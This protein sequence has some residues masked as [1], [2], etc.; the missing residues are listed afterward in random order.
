M[1]VS[2]RTLS[3]LPE[4]SS[5]QL[6]P[7]AYFEVSNPVSAI[8]DLN[9][10]IISVNYI[11]AS[12]KIK[13]E[14]V[15]RGI[16]EDVKYELKNN[17]GIIDQDF[18]WLYRDHLS[19]VHDSYTLT[20]RK[21]FS[22]NPTHTNEITSFT[23]SRLNN[24]SI[25][26]DALKKYSNL[27]S[28]P[29][30][31]P[32][33]GFVTHLSGT[34]KDAYYNL[35]RIDKNGKQVT[36]TSEPSFVFS[37]SSAK[38]LAQNEF[39]FKIEPG[40]RESKVWEA[41]ASGIFTCYGWLDEIHNE[42]VSN[43]NR[44]IALMGK[45]E[46]LGVWTT[47]QVQP[48]IKNNYLSYV[49]FTFPVHKG[50]KLKVVTGFPVG[51]NSDKYFKNGS[52]L[53]NN[54]ANAFLG[55]VYTGL[56][57][58]NGGNYNLS[59]INKDPVQ[60]FDPTDLCNLVCAQISHELTCDD[61]INSNI[62]DISGR[63][64]I[65]QTEVEKRVK[66]IDTTLPTSDYRNATIVLYNRKLSPNSTTGKDN[67]YQQLYWSDSDTSGS[68]WRPIYVI[69]TEDLCKRND[70]VG[71]GIVRNYYVPPGPEHEDKYGSTENGIV[72]RAYV[73][74][75]VPYGAVF[76]DGIRMFYK[77]SQ[78]CTVLIRCFSDI[79]P[80]NDTATRCAM[81]YGYE[82]NWRYTRCVPMCR[83]VEI[84]GNLTD[85]PAEITL[86][87][88]KG[89]IFM[90][91][92]WLRGPYSNDLEYNVKHD[93]DG[94]TR[95]DFGAS[96]Y[97]LMN[98]PP[99]IPNSD[100]STVRLGTI[101]DSSISAESALSVNSIGFTYPSYLIRPDKEYFDRWVNVD[102]SKTTISYPLFRGGDSGSGA[103]ARIVEMPY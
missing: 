95:D 35:F 69:K 37:P 53:A 21:N 28:S 74:A 23:N 9:G 68:I 57:V 100:G 86:P 22:S 33:F 96:Y 48:F 52:S 8:A 42:K 83:Q 43:E 75:T 79:S 51:S 54:L 70:T 31:S 2:L 103:I 87:V 99:N 38:T 81:L 64:E 17:N 63:V 32:Q 94:N 7:N 58:D 15:S 36:V 72:E 11:Y 85:P 14:E 30:I 56:S 98:M 90:F 41:P 78:D 39:V 71:V 5:A 44:W 73:P 65:L 19:L 62:S 45:Q 26:L 77:V 50:L 92:S 13:K 40:E 102:S 59:F 76:T 6:A 10:N 66:Y 49:G 1:A 46:Q 3:Q 82:T 34:S 89:T 25:N 97:K 80:Y 60:N 4:I 93:K 61:V 20:G 18:G 88:K 16:A 91:E 47:L 101:Y 84:Y 55:G 67:N 27:N 24:Y 29:A 12:K